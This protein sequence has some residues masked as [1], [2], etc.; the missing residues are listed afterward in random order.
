[1]KRDSINKDEV[2][3][4]RHHHTYIISRINLPMR[5]SAIFTYAIT[6]AWNYPAFSRGSNSFCNSPTSQMRWCWEDFDDVSEMKGKNYSTERH[7][8]T[9]RHYES[10][11]PLALST[12]TRLAEALSGSM[13]VY[14]WMN[15]IW[16]WLYFAPPR[17]NP[18]K[19]IPLGIQA[20]KS[21]LVHRDN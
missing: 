17:W 19:D 16:L 8:L 9:A 14:S 3:C 20:R 1:M 11:R 18:L 10:R 2:S 4:H 12:H 5:I 15:S 6:D 21:M 7:W 13:P